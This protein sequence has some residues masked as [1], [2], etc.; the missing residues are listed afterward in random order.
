MPTLS[1]QTA[2]SQAIDAIRNAESLLTE[3]IQSADET[4]TAIKLT[5]EYNNLDSYLSEL[6]HAQNSA[7]DVTFTNATQALQARADG[8]KADEN[9]IK[10]I[11]A[12]V[13][14]AGKIVGYITQALG[15]ITKL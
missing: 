14:T 1:Q 3:Q 10:T 4:L 15:F 12:D 2:V 13:A 8:L 11:V 9:T 6:L 5:H 7:D